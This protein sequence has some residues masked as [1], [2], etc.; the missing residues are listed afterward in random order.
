MFNYIYKWKKIAL[1]LLLILPLLSSPAALGVTEAVTVSTVSSILQ[2]VHSRPALC[3]MRYSWHA[4]LN[5]CNACLWKYLSE[6]LCLYWMQLCLQFCPGDIDLALLPK[7]ILSF[8][9]FNLFCS[10]WRAQEL[11]LPYIALVP[12][13]MIFRFR[14]W[15]FLLCRCKAFVWTCIFAWSQ[16]NKLSVKA[17][18]PWA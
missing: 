9:A 10:T 18:L 5:A 2:H 8:Q 17:A 1:F 4:Q 3:F 7:H 16:V 13:A 14:F 6:D 12:F 11:G 15:P